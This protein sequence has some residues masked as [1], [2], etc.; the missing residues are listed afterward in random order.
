MPSVQALR[1]MLLAHLADKYGVALESSSKHPSD[2][3][4]DAH[5][6]LQGPC[7]QAVEAKIQALS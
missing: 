6:L 2:G 1:L 3:K 7:I 4:G 5:D